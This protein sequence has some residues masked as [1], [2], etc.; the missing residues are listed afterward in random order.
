MRSA[1]ARRSAPA[2]AYIRRQ[3]LVEA[4]VLGLGRRGARR[5]PGRPRRGAA[6]HHRHPIAMS[7]VATAAAMVVA[8]GIGLVFGV[9]PASRAARLAPSTP[10][11]ANEDSRS[12]QSRSSTPLMNLSL[13]SPRLAMT[14]AARPWGWPSPRAAGPVTAAISAAA[15]PPRPA[16][17]RGRPGHRAPVRQAAGAVAPAGVAGLLGDRSLAPPDPWRPSRGSRWR[18]KTSRRAR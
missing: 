1:C 15:T 14:S 13:R 5:R 18:C 2:P 3:F 9:Y 11:A 4:S 17:P 6:A 7:G 8:I 16:P 12:T 10:C